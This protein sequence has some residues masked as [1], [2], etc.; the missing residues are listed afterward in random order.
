LLGIAGVAFFF[1]SPVR[2]Y[3][4]DGAMIQSPSRE[5]LARAGLSANPELFLE[6]LT[7]VTSRVASYLV[8]CNMPVKIKPLGLP[9]L[10]ERICK[11]EAGKA[12]G[13]KLLLAKVLFFF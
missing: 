6:L 8:G 5:A 1:R 7:K 9:S 3:Q 4:Y 10:W 11:L 12:R 2:S 13:G